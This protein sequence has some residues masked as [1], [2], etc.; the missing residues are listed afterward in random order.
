MKNACEMHRIL[1]EAG[2]YQD[3]SSVSLSHHM[4]GFYDIYA[5]TQ[6]TSVQISVPYSHHTKKEDRSYT[7]HCRPAMEA[8]LDTIEDPDLH[9]SFIFYPE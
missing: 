3:V 9:P 4:K 8:I 7:V 1:A 5:N 6:F 2:E